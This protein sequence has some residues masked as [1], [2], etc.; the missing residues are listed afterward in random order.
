MKYIGEF[1]KNSTILL[2]LLTKDDKNQPVAVD[3]SPKATIELCSQNGLQEVDSVTL[4]TMGDISR[5]V[6]SYR[7]PGHWS[8]GSY[9]ITYRVSIDGI[10]YQIKE[11]FDVIED[12]HFNIS[13]ANFQEEPVIEEPISNASESVMPHDFQAPS[14]IHVDGNK[15]VIS[16]SDTH[17]Y[18]N[19]YQ[20]VLGEDIS[21]TSGLRLGQTKVLTFTSE[22]KP[23][24]CTPLEVRSVLLDL[25]RHFTPHE[26]Y[27]AIRDASEKA[28]QLLG[29]V[30]DANSSRYRDLSDTD[31]AY[32]PSQKYVLYEASLKLMASLMVKILNGESIES[33]QSSSE[34]KGSITLG[35]FSISTG[36]GGTS[37]SQ[38]TKESTLEKLQVLMAE[39]EKELKFWKD[40]MLGR[41]R[42]GYASPV[43]AS[44]RVDAG[45]P[46]GRDFE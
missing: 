26:I 31:T 23:L 37:S 41:N 12:A 7:I 45:S 22:Y 46:T 5:H 15:I 9:I 30:A 1:Q 32:Y 36:S 8:G 35:D 24:F 3:Y 6:L 34:I 38:E 44:F 14:D 10:E 42:R 33:K 27:S 16:L 13:S 43:S 18:N 29:N 19:T 4:K 40:S 2:E 17:L 25:F 21:S 11:K 20:V 28:M 39:T